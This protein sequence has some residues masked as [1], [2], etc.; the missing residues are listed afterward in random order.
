MNRVVIREGEL[1][2]RQKDVDLVQKIIDGGTSKTIAEEE[3]VS[4]RTI[5]SRRS[6]LI[7]RIGV[8]NNAELVAYFLKNNLVNHE[9]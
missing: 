1:V 7:K 5:E 4:P 8:K 3:G 6:K 9:R 2:L